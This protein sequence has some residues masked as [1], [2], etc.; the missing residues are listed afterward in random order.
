MQA[1]R[2][3]F[4]SRYIRYTM[5]FEEINAAK[6][7]GLYLKFLKKISTT[8]VL[9]ID[10]FIMQQASVQDLSSLMDIIEEKQQTGS[11]IITT[12]YPIAK[13]HHRMP[14]QTIA[15]A[16]CDR[17]V[18]SAYKF[19]LKGDGGSMRGTYKKSQAK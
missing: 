9:I 15:D 2:M 1:C 5:L 7:T 17:L 18:A 13:W 3:G 8:N 16:I 4:S 10:D 11:I 19:N 14:D 12:Q 6:A